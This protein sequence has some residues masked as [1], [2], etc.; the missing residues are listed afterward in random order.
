[1]SFDWTI[2]PWL[3]IDTESTGVDPFTARIVEVAVV[4]IDVDGNAV[5]PWCKVVNPGVEIPAE[6]AAIHGISTSRAEAE[7]I[8]TAE[9]LACVA[10]RIFQHGWRCPVVA[11]NATYDWPLLIQEAE[12]CGVEFPAFAP[13]LDPFL[14]DRMLSTRSGKRNLVAVSDH[15]NVALNP[16]DAHGALADAIAAGRVMRKLVERY[17]QIGEHTLGSVYLRQVQ[18]HERDRERFVDWMRR[19]R[20]PDFDKPSGWPIP[21]T[22]EA[23]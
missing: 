1:M 12:R 2:A 8:P 11:F 4:E 10:D 14:V 7:G 19:N 20:D 22:S 23:S 17:P 13:V 18:G 9:A 3:A 21:S 16:D 15:Y 6:A 5:D